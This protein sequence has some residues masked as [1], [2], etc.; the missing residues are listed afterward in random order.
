MKHSTQP[1]QYKATDGKQF[2]DKH[3]K[4]YYQEQLLEKKQMQQEMEYLENDRVPTWLWPDEDHQ[5]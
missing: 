4:E 1:Y 2:I 3:D 5:C